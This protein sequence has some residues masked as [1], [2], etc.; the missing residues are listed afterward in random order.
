MKKNRESQQARV[1]KYLKTHKKGLTSAMAFWRLGMITRLGARIF[2][3]RQK[4]YHICT[5]REPNR[6]SEG[7]HGRY[8]YLGE[9]QNWWEHDSFV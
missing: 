2:E 1:L 7:F 4:G 3:L 8:V 5:L 9:E 6:F